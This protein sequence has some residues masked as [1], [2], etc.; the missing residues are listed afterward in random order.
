MN[1]LLQAIIST[2]KKLYGSLPEQ[3]SPETPVTKPTTQQ[4]TTS[5]P[6][7]TAT[8]KEEPK[9][10][11][12]IVEPVP[13]PV[14]IEEVTVE[15]SVIEV[16]KT[17]TDN[18]PQDSIQRRHALFRLRT[19]VETLKGPRPSDS[20]QSRHYDALINNLVTQALTDKIVLE[21][22]YNSYENLPKT[23]VQADI[24]PTANIQES[25]IKVQVEE[26]PVTAQIAQSEINTDSFI[27]APPTDSIL[28]RHY[29]TLIN[30]EINRLLE[31]C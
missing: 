20:I 3:N 26:T 18:F 6:I 9:V 12:S 11:E 29:D 17:T 4:N 19:I 15:A 16:S 31:R 23:L 7:V 30:N 25:I 14:R 24:K 27:P 22:L 1:K 28:R 13:E 8:A 5:Q 10:N 21:N 2:V